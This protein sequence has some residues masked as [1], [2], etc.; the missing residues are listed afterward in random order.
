MADPSFDAT[1]NE[2][3]A[4]Q[5]VAEAHGVPFLAIRGISDGAG[6][7]LRLPGFPLQFFFYKQLAADNAARVAAAFLQRLD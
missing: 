5:V 2:T 6:D 4:V 7:P 3:A 1:D